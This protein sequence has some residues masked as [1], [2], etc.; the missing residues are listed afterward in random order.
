MN[1][2][3][4][5]LGTAARLVALGLALL[6]V[7]LL[8]VS[9][10]V[11]DVGQVLFSADSVSA[12]LT[13]V[14]VD[15]GLARQVMLDEFL[16][17]EFFAGLGGEALDARGAMAEL[18]PADK[19]TIADLLLPQEWL[20]EQLGAVI[21]N[22]YAWIDSDS[23]WPRLAL[24]IRPIKDHMLSGGAKD[25]IDIVIDSWPA[26]TPEQMEAM[27]SEV[28]RTGQVR[29]EYCE[30]PEPF[31]SALLGAATDAMMLQ[32]RDMPTF[33]PLLGERDR[34]ETAEGLVRLKTRLR[35][36]RAISQW[37]WMVPLSLLGLIMALAIR[38]WRDL[39]RWWGIPLTLGG[40]LSF[41]PVVIGGG[42]G[43][44]FLRARLPA[45]LVQYPRLGE[46]VIE[47][48]LSLR[49]AALGALVFH[50]ALATIAGLVI[51][52]VFTWI[53]R[54]TARSADLEPTTVALEPEA[55]PAPQAAS[56]PPPPP[57]PPMEE[58][59]TPSGMFG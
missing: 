35:Q 16:T 33:L 53:G 47:V 44:A 40:L 26:C 3:P 37:G 39:A 14:F 28:L 10:L 54:R 25:L 23:P 13:R 32:V 31:R 55:G 48:M 59:D 27:Q 21:S 8:P 42:M 7:V 2:K 56:P 49:R 19:Q 34:R 1:E 6:F 52:G 38:S 46:A 57:P 50:A 51:L 4:G 22:A 36:L 29:L 15:S 30:P 20:R 18:S 12:V 43:G 17:D 41:V 24:D 45:E 58:D 5:C 11:H 9:L